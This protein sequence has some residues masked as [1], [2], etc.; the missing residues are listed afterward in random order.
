MNFFGVE[1][2]DSPACW[3]IAY[4][5]YIFPCGN[6]IIAHGDN[7]T[8]TAV[9]CFLPRQELFLTGKLL[10]RKRKEP[11]RTGIDFLHSGIIFSPDSNDAFAVR[12]G[13]L[14]IGAFVKLSNKTTTMLS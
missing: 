9:I 11:L 14:A 6:W 10:Q 2:F 5:Q 1:L 13:W 3:I 4:P 7:S 8:A 12:I